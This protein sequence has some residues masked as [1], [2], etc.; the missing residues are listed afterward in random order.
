MPALFMISYSI[1]KNNYF[2]SR[3]NETNHDIK[4]NNL[5]IKHFKYKYRDTQ[6]YGI[7]ISATFT[8]QNATIYTH[9]YKHKI[10]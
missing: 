8:I 2:K 4:R 9:V 1:K 6:L 5:N 3:T 7:V 10:I